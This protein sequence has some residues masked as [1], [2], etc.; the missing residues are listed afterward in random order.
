MSRLSS[1]FAIAVIA[2]AVYGIRVFLSRSHAPLSCTELRTTDGVIALGNLDAQISG[3]YRLA[4]KAKLTVAQSSG[5]IELIAQRGQFLGQISDYEKAAA[6]AEELVREN[7]ENGLAY[8]ARARTYSIF[9]KFSAALADIETAERL[10]VK[11]ARVDSARASILQAT[12]HYAEALNI[13]QRLKEKRPDI[14]SVSAL[15]SVHAEQGEIDKADALFTAAPSFYRDV[16]PFPIAWLYF[17]QGVMWM[18]NEDYPRA[19]EFLENAHAR[20]PAYKAV[21]GHL[22]EVEAEMGNRPRAI[23][24]LRPLAESADDP[25]YAAHLAEILFQDGQPVEAEKWRAAAAARY[26]ELMSLHPEAFADHATEFW[27]AAGGDAK[28]ALGY[29][30]ANLKLRPTPRAHELVLNAALK[31]GDTPKTCATLKSAAA[32]SRPAPGLASAMNEARE[33]CGG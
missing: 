15:A 27:L 14:G 29:A 3:E 9:H 28:K 7:P 4:A 2:L 33:V 23:E 6:L 10:G 19:R 30:E 32:F 12:G 16:S 25:D 5:I 11:G 26:D 18:R 31:A 22:A 24:L 8:L 13:R 20:L 17:Q 1:L 21:Q